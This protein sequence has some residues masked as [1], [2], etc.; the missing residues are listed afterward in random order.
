M[1]FVYVLEVALQHLEDDLEIILQLL[2]SLSI[3]Y[4]AFASSIWQ[5]RNNLLLE[6]KD[7][8]IATIIGRAQ[9]FLV[10][11]LLEQQMKNNSNLSYKITFGPHI[12]T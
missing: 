3:N 11:W 4:R 2:S 7:E 1:G 5:S 6:K 10:D 12:F 9:T 8:N